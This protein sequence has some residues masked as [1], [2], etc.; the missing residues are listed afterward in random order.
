MTFR[1]VAHTYLGWLRD[2]KGA[3]PWTLADYGYLV[4]DAGVQAKRDERV[5]NAHIMAALGGKSA[6][7]ITT[8]VES[9]LKAVAKSGVSARSVNE[10]RS[11]VSAIFNYGCKESTFGLP[12]IPIPGPTSARD[13]SGT[14]C[15]TTPQR[16]LRPSRAP[17]KR[18]STVIPPDRLSATRRRPSTPLRTTRT[19]R[20]S[21]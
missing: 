19:Q 8:R 10:H 6:A 9:M 16:M 15:P 12:S 2:V 7:R 20:S 18:A 4:A 5:S 17:W 1:E 11:V 13:P 3:T 21:A 14:R